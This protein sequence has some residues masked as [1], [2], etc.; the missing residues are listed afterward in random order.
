MFVFAQNQQHLVSIKAPGIPTT[1]SPTAHYSHHV[2]QAYLLPP[3]LAPCGDGGDRYVNIRAVILKNVFLH[4]TCAL[5][6]EK[7]SLER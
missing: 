2:C 3:R 6:G 4:F 1:A 7:R 5:T